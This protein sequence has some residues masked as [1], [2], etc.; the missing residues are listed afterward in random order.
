MFVQWIMLKF[1]R[2]DFLINIKHGEWNIYTF[3][4]IG[5]GPLEIPGIPATLIWLHLQELMSSPD[6]MMIFCKKQFSQNEPIT[7]FQLGPIV[8]R[9]Y[10]FNDNYVM[11]IFFFGGIP[12]KLVI[13]RRWRR[14][15]NLPTIFFG[16]IFLKTWRFGA[17]RW[18]SCWTRFGRLPYSAIMLVSSFD[19]C[20]FDR[21]FY[22]SLYRLHILYMYMFFICTHAVLKS[23]SSM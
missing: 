14:L 21:Y 12:P 17:G 10:K 18:V 22:R 20:L 4:R 9:T 8:G 5:W 3:H 13:S 2:K 6:M 23:V 15:V 1:L 7:A 16:I 11:F 19:R